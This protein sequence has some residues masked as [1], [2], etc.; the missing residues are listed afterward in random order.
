MRVESGE[1][2]W[3]VGSG[4]WRAESEI[5]TLQSSAAPLNQIV[6][7]KPSL[8]TFSVF[9]RAILCV[10]SVLKSAAESEIITNG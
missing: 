5:I 1:R 6:S 2:E 8:K 7:F 4:E 10:N 9:L 3:G